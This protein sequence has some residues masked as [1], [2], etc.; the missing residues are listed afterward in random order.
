MKKYPYP[1]KKLETKEEVKDYIQEL[2]G[3]A[4]GYLQIDGWIGWTLLPGDDGFITD[5][6]EMNISTVYPYKKYKLSVEQG[7]L[8]NCLKEKP[9]SPF[10]KNLERDVFHELT[11]ILT[12]PLT[13]I[14]EKRYT[15]ADEIRDANEH[16][17]DHFSIA[18]HELVGDFREER[19]RA[20]C[21]EKKLKKKPKKKT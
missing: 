19:D 2:V 13:R 11:H 14:G 16:L 5:N 1:D 8:D 10:W 17:T 3:N 21:A 18:F 7:H 6:S 20:D 4:L 15:N 12:D 9:D